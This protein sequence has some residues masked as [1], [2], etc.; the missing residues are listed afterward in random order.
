MTAPAELWR[1]SVRTSG[2]SMPD[3]LE[4]FEEE[5]LSVSVFEIEVDSAQW[6]FLKNRLCELIDPE[7]DSLRIYRLSEPRARYVRLHGTQPE[8]DLREP[9]IV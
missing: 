1:V 9:L 7:Q 8:F 4:Q 6:T 3:V 5:A 2:P